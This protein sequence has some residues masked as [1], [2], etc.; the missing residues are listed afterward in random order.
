[1][2]HVGNARSRSWRATSPLELKGFYDAIFSHPDLAVYVIRVCDDGTFRIDDA[3]AGVA[4]LAKRPVDEISGLT[5]HE[6]LIE[7]IADCLETNLRVC[8]ETG[9]SLQYERELDLPDGRL[10]W[11]TTLIPTTRQAGEPVHVVGVTRDISYEA[12]MASVAEHHEAL[13]K[14]LGSTLPN[15]IY[16]Y[17]LK[18][19][20]VCFTAGAESRPLGY[21]PQQFIEMGNELVPL[22]VHPDDQDRVAAHL[23]D[24]AR[25]DDGEISSIEYRVRHLDGRYRHFLSRETVFNRDDAGEVELIL[26][27]SED[28]TEQDRMQEEVRDLSERL[29]MLQ[30]EE[31]RVIAQELHDSTAQHLIAADLAL[32]RIREVGAGGEGARSDP[33][34]IETALDDAQQ[35]LQEAKREIRVQTFLLHPPLL[36]SRGLGDAVETFA[37]GF[38]ARAGLEIEAHIDQRADRVSD[39]F[40]VALFRVCQEALTNVYRHARASKVVITLALD[41]RELSLTVLDNGIGADQG[42]WST[43]P[44]RGV[45][46]SGMR[47]RMERLG[48]SIL[49]E[50]GQ[51]GTRLVATAPLVERRPRRAARP[52]APGRESFSKQ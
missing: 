44:R 24:L 8:L 20:R 14:G 50:A 11:K 18:T 28:N 9:S 39:E 23:Q 32:E 42:D 16:L 27:V 2:N 46:L 34:F 5:P 36:Q 52:Q 35:S 21:R 4:Q 25:L 31:R 40:A 49:V 10:A 12:R 3:N 30:I 1:M 47:E 22:L 51:P 37:T 26:G 41:G 45:G 19:Q 48:G 38:A 6:C 13:L 43:G 33:D 7:P 17:D 15:I 29:L